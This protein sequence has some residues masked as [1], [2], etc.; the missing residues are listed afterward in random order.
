MRA[1]LLKVVKRVFDGMAEQQSLRPWIGTPRA[2][3]ARTRGVESDA[4]VFSMNNISRPWGQS[5]EVTRP[6]TIY[7]LTMGQRA[8]AVGTDEFP[9]GGDVGG[10]QRGLQALYLQATVV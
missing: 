2:G 6:A 9:R 4:D 10:Q 8:C 5:V 7:S 3:Y 1:E